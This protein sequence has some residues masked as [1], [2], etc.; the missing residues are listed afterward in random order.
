MLARLQAEWQAIRYGIAEWLDS[1]PRWRC[2]KCKEWLPDDECSC[3]EDEDDD[4]DIPF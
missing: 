4:D 3:D 2:P 1:R